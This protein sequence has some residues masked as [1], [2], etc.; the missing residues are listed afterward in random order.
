MWLSVRLIVCLPCALTSLYMGVNA[1]KILRGP[2]LSFFPSSPCNRHS[3][4]VIAGV[5]R[6][7]GPLQVK[8]L[9]CPDPLTRAALP[10][11]SLYV[12]CGLQKVLAV[13]M[14][15]KVQAVST[16]KVPGCRMVAGTSRS[17]TRASSACVDEVAAPR[18]RPSCVYGPTVSGNASRDTAA[19]SDVSTTAQP[20]PLTVRW[21]DLSW[22]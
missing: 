16:V 6:T 14:A 3:V 8:I 9:G 12:A 4:A 1:L 13:P 15:V 21:V 5:Q 20:L 10:P 17:V 2:P 11:M 18:V 19:S 7:D 22:V